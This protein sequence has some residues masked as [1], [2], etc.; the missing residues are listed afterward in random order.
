MLFSFPCMGKSGH[1]DEC[2][3]TRS[4]HLDCLNRLNA[5]GS[6]KFTVPFLEAEDKPNGFVV[7]V[8]AV[9]IKAACAPADADPYTRRALF[10]SVAVKPWSWDLNKPEM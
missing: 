3:E 9:N 1:L 7:V 6:L 10:E 2:I 5:K 4:V 8:E